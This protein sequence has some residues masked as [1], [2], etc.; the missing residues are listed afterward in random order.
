MKLQS[1]NKTTKFNAIFFFSLC[2]SAAFSDAADII[3]PS[4]DPNCPCLEGPFNLTMD[5]PIPNDDYYDYIQET[6]L[7]GTS[8][9]LSSYGAG[10]KAHDEISGYCEWKQKKCESMLPKKQDCHDLEWCSRSWCYVETTSCALRSSLSSLFEE[11]EYSYA[12]CGDM[13]SFT[14]N[15][16]ISSLQGKT[17]RAA[18]N[19]NTGG[20]LG[21]YNKEG[22]FALNNEWTGAIVDFVSTAAVAGGFDIEVVAPPEFLREEAIKFFNSTSSFDFCVYATALGYVDLCVGE[23]TLTNDRIVASQWFEYVTHSF[24]LVTFMQKPESVLKVFWDEASTLLK[25]FQWRVWLVIF[26]LFMPFMSLI[27]LYF[28]YGRSDGAFPSTD[29]KDLPGY[30]AKSLYEVFLSLFVGYG[31]PVVSR[32]GKAML[33]GIGF[34]NLLI[35]AVYTANLAATLNFNNLEPKV[36]SLEDA[37]A[38]GYRVCGERASIH[39]LNTTYPIL[40]ELMLANPSDGLAGF[41]SRSSVLDAMKDMVL[42]EEREMHCEAAIVLKED[43]MAMQAEGLH[44][45]KTMIGGS[46]G[47]RSFALPI[48]PQ[49]F[50][51][52]WAIFQ[53]QYNQGVFD[54]AARRAIPIK[55]CPDLNKKGSSVT[56]SMDQMIGVWLGTFAFAVAGIMMCSA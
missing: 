9:T 19:S 35:V 49:Y 41:K 51:S 8:S 23:Y 47:I 31:G 38:Q 54:N 21:A 39:L 14:G 42:P 36:V 11:M 53:D 22:S 15:A 3:S 27:I 18:F 52:V 33:L 13:D 12:T 46:I 2:M 44:C 34:F 20:Y 50:E 45:N 10:C 37:Y 43:I 30:I 24:Y 6:I 28:D 56:L 40:N 55:E 32:A 29:K 48:S 25:P 7:S 4:G 17:I 16:L 26:F 5:F 1:K